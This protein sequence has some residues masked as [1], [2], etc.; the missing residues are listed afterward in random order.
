[1]PCFADTELMHVLVKMS[2]NMAMDFQAVEEL[3]RYARSALKTTM[4]I[5]ALRVQDIE[6]IFRNILQVFLIFCHEQLLLKKSEGGFDLI[7]SLTPPPNVEH[8]GIE[9]PAPAFRPLDECF[10]KLQDAVNAGSFIINVRIPYI[11]DFP[12]FK[13]CYRYQPILVA[14][15]RTKLQ[16]HLQ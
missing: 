4:E 7:F 14:M 12:F 3:Q 8:L 9:L 6:V 2:W 13:F 1:M 10:Q 16:L 15:H 11:K 5:T